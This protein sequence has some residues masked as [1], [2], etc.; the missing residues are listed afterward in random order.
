VAVYRSHRRNKENIRDL[1]RRAGLVSFGV[2]LPDLY[3]PD[4][5]QEAQV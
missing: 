4:I 2:T 1:V 3:R 5:I